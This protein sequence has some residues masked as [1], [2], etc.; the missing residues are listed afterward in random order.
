MS[1]LA[2]EQVVRACGVENF[3]VG[4]IA[5][6]RKFQIV[7]FNAMIF[8]LSKHCLIVRVLLQFC[9]AMNFCVELF[10]E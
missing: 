3:K 1:F 2:R 10:V 7:P 6:K 8:D 4:S 9:V 5:N